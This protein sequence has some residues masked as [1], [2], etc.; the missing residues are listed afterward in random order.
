[1][2]IYPGLWCL[3]AWKLFPIRL[4][5]ALFEPTPTDH[6]TETSALQRLAWA[7]LCAAGWVAMEMTIGRFLTGFP[8]NFLGASQFR[9][10]PLIQIASIT[11]VY[12]VS[13]VMVWFACSVFSAGMSFTRQFA[14]RR[15]LI[16][17]A[18]PLLAVIA[19]FVY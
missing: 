18:A 14:S 5:G 12:G 13:F 2:A 1:L 4:R 15:W 8:W 6:F 7:L 10:L 11:G 19:L 17:I 9:M 3:L 16:E